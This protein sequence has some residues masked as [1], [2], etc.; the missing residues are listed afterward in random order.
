VPLMQTDKIPGLKR[1]RKIKD[2]SGHRFG[3]LVAVELVERLLNRNH[4]WSFKCDCGKSV[5]VNIKSVR[6]GN[7]ASCGCLH[8]ERLIARNSTHKLSKVY[9]REYQTWKDMRARCT[10]VA[11]KDYGDYGGRGINVCTRWNDFSKFIED[12]GPRQVGFTIDRI[13]VNKGYCPKNCRWASAKVQANNKR[14]NV[15]LTINGETRTLQ[16]WS[17]MHGVSRSKVRWRLAQGWS[18]EKAFSGNDF[19]KPSD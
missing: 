16:E 11:S 15:R 3:R 9:P 13:D 7:T 12:M 19:R 10:R 14:S 4:R 5:V 6:S 18:L 8:K 1:N 17:D 2:Y